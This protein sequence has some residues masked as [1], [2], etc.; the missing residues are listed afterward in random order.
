MEAHEHDLLKKEA[1]EDEALKEYEREFQFF[2]E[3][4]E[5]LFDKIANTLEVI[6]GLESSDFYKNDF[7]EYIKQEIQDML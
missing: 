4:T 5:P 1:R 7:K 6:K 3:D 2:K